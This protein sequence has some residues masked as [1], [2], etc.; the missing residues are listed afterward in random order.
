MKKKRDTKKKKGGFF[1]TYIFITANIICL[2][3]SQRSTNRVRAGRHGSESTSYAS[4]DRLTSRNDLN[5]HKTSHMNAS[6]LQKNV[7]STVS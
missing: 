1:P 2:N 3:T 7:G 4:F 5:K 6:H